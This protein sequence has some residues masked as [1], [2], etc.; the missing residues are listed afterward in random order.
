MTEEE[1]AIWR[2]AYAAAFVA[3]FRHVTRVAE[4]IAVRVAPGEPPESPDETAARITHA[5][6][7]AWIAEHA[8]RRLREWRAT[9]DPEAGIRLDDGD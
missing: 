7:P 9:E 3:D 6:R 2:A 5:E 8:V 4:T 1:R